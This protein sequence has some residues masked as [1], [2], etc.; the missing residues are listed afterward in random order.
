V[1]NLAW[2]IPLNDKH[3]Y[4]GG[5]WNLLHPYALLVSLTTVALFMMHGA[6]YL[7]MKTEGEL[8][9]KIREWVKNTMI[10]FIICYVVTTMGT[11]LYVPRMAQPFREHPWWGIV[12]VVNMLAI[13]N[14]PR[15]IYH[16]RDFNA[17]LSSCVAILCL[18]AL[19]AI[20]L[21]PYMI[22]SNPNP[23][24]SLNIWMG[25]SSIKT[26]GIMLIIAIIGMPL[27]LAYT[28]SIY[29]I[30]RGKV[31]LEGSSY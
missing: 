11:L 13:A 26:L 30:F 2:G 24:N 29:W 9:D 21:F 1:G 7:V 6:I 14:V 3:E 23:E 10:F 19:L 22:P 28:I 27:V 12:A 4:I 20:G 5:F 15:E 31:K 16:K 17:F 25:A 18:M 8:H